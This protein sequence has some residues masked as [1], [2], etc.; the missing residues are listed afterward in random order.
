MQRHPVALM[1]LSTPIEPGS[2]RREQ[3]PNSVRSVSPA[4]GVVES[5]TPA[6]TAAFGRRDPAVRGAR[7]AAGIQGTAPHMAS[8]TSK[9][10]VSR[11]LTRQPADRV[12][13]YDRFW[14]ETELD[15]RKALHLEFPPGVGW[16]NADAWAHRHGTLWEHFGFDLLEVGWPDYCLR[17]MK[18]EVLDETDNWVL[19]RDGNWAELR[20]WKHKMGTPEHI[21]YGIDTPQRWQEVRHLIRPTRN[22]IRWDE[23]RPLFRRAREANRFVCYG[24]VEPFEMIKDVLGHEIMLMAMIEEPD[25]IHDVFSTYTD[26]A[27]Q[28]FQMAEAEGMACDGAFVYGDMAYRNGPFMSPAHYREFLQPYHKK[29]FAEFT[30]RGMPVIYHSDGDIRLVL[31]DLIEAGVSAINPMENSANMDLRELALRWGDRLSFVGNIDVKVLATND[32]DRVREEIRVKMAAAMPRQGYVYHS[33]HSVPPGV[34][35]DTYRLVLAEVD[36]IGRY[37]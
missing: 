1:I 2:V 22:R 36:R 4:T 17:R 8:L 12:P 34:T 5:P 21:R 11:T 13:R 18:P 20:W 9:E 32:P 25:W 19:Q 35:L 24:T 3:S 10:R 7:P 14:F 29:M 16:G 26:V 31:D 15:F 28:L 27:V 23:F 30:K 33:D 37:E 6:Y